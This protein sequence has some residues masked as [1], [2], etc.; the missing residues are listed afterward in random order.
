MPVR[1]D[2]HTGTV[3]HQANVQD[4]NSASTMPTELARAGD[5]YRIRR[6]RGHSTPE[7]RVTTL[8]PGLGA[9]EY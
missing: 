9:P 5:R 3:K 8:T 4:Y 7:G 1:S 6:S 2:I